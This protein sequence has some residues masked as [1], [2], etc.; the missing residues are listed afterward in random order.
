MDIIA[1]FLGNI[2]TGNLAVVEYIIRLILAI[3]LGFSIGLERKMRLKEAG[4]RTHTIMCLGACLFTLLSIG[5]FS[6]SD[7]ARIA[8]QIVPGIG[9]I[10][11]GMIFY[12]KNAIH[13][14]TTAAGVWTTAAIGMA[15]G[16]GWYIVSLVATALIIFIQYVMHTNFKV[17]KTSKFIKIKVV[18]IDNNGDVSDRVREMFGVERFSK[19]SAKKENEDFVFTAV[20]ST[21]K[22]ISA[23]NI[24]SMIKSNQNIL[25]ISREDD[26]E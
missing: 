7:P 17:F 1:K 3:A 9:F 12:R 13:G 15:V 22:N 19:I 2:F 11:A 14:L 20:I 6:G 24:H 16:A 21:D 8:A 5:A 23:N 26:E 18:F 4:P 25:S 10:G